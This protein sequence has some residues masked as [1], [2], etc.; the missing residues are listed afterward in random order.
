MRD[1]IKR[2]ENQLFEMEEKL[3]IAKRFE[4]MRIGLEQIMD[5]ANEIS[6]CNKRYGLSREI[7]DTTVKIQSLIHI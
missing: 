6:E 5:Y 3:G 4:E 7:N 1:S 2:A